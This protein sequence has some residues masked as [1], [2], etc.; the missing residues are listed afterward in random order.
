MVM[1][2]YSTSHFYPDGK[3]VW[4]TEGTR[5]QSTIA[6]WAKLINAPAEQEN[7][8]HM[9]TSPCTLDAGGDAPQL[10]S[11]ETHR[12]RGTQDNPAGAF[13]N[14]KSHTPGRDPVRARG[15]YGLP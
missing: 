4:M 10:T 15:G 11:K 3:I 8:L 14:P 9:N 6:E 5:Y 7:V 13:E 1:Q 2:F 12:K